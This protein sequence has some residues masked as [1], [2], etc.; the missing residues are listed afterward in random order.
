MV[1]Y[2]EHY[3]PVVPFF[4]LTC[5]H[6]VFGWA[7]LQLRSSSSIVCSVI[8]DHRSQHGAAWRTRRSR[9]GKGE[10]ER[11]GERERWRWW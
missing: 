2:F 6:S 7:A 5:D 3:F 1:N 9:K 10:S 11:K 8:T 4:V